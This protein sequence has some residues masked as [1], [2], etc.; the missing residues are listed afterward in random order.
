VINEEYIDTLE[1]LLDEICVRA[2]K[3]ESDRYD[4]TM[5]ELLRQS[6][7]EQYELM[8]LGLWARDR[9]IPAMR[10]VLRSEQIGQSLANDIANVLEKLPKQK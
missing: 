4:E 6:F 5:T 3:G 1:K 10:M 7:R 2:N 8:R 9:G